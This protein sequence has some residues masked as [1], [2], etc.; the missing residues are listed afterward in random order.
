M[1]YLRDLALSSRQMKPMKHHISIIV[2][3]FSALFLT[4]CEAIRKNMAEQQAKEDA[5]IAE[6]Q[7]QCEGMSIIRV[8]RM[9]GEVEGDYDYF[10]FVRNSTRRSMLVR[11]RFKTGLEIS[12][13]NS[14]KVASNDIEKAFL[15][16][17]TRNSAALVFGSSVA[18]G[19]CS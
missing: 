8:E 18:F 11:L 16:T 14:F 13:T 4:G 12:Y 6:Q 17:S 3:L 9:N 2:L 19:G 15:A 1:L 10:A 5:V 7:A